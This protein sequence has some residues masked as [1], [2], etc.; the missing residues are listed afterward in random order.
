MAGTTPQ[1]NE[2]VLTLEAVRWGVRELMAQRIHP[3]FLAYLHLRKEAAR[4]ESEQDIRPNWDELGEFMRVSGGPPGKPYFRPLWHGKAT[5]PGRYWLNPNLA[6][7]YAPSSLRD[8]PYRVIDTNGSRFSL[9][10]DHAELAREFLLYRE[11]VPVVALGAYLYRDFAIVADAFPQPLDLARLVYRDF[12]FGRGSVG[13]AAALFS[14]EASG[15]PGVWFEPLSAD[16]PGV[17]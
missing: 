2:Y 7:S 6:G 9:R 4:Q 13:E 5:D 15:G 3:F 12:A 17:E 8:V 14:S 1:A 16:T 11:T 10:P